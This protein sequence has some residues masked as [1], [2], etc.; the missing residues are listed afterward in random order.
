MQKNEQKELGIERNS[1]ASLNVILLK[2][3]VIFS[4]KVNEKIC[5]KMTPGQPTK[6][7]KDRRL[8][9]IKHSNS[10]IHMDLILKNETTECDNCTIEFNITELAKHK[11]DCGGNDMV[12]CDKCKRFYNKGLCIARHL[13][14]CSNLAT[15]DYCKREL[16]KSNLHKH[17]RGTCSHSPFPKIRKPPTKQYNREIRCDYCDKKVWTRNLQSHLHHCWAVRKVFGTNFK[18]ESLLALGTCDY[19][20]RIMYRRSL[21]THFRSCSKQSRIDSGLTEIAEKKQGVVA[22][23]SCCKEKMLRKN[24]SRHFKRCT[25]FK[26]KHKPKVFCDYCGKLISKSYR[27]EHLKCCTTYLIKNPGTVRCE[28]IA[29]INF[30][31]KKEIKEEVLDSIDDLD[32]L[33]V[34]NKNEKDF[35]LSG[36]FKQEVLKFE[37]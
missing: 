15:C 25:G 23:C 32:P 26:R 24:L 35:E 30:I 18:S 11:R 31:V 13:R 10:K 6:G 14:R 16:L 28:E 37:N 17:F 7:S 3:I 12:K 19:C 36:Y 20:N 9:L 33:S 29:Q 2:A 4:I 1:D 34:E 22:T 5:V 27:K 21:S 8:S